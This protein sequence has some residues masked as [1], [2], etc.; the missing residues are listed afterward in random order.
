MSE[1]PKRMGIEGD[2]YG[3]KVD[4]VLDSV[5]HNLAREDFLRLAWACVD[6]ASSMRTVRLS[7]RALGA[8]ED[9]Y[10]AEEPE[11]LREGTAP[12]PVVKLSKEEVQVLLSIREGTYDITGDFLNRER[13]VPHRLREK[14][15]ITF[16]HKRA[17]L[18][19]VL[20][21]LGKSVAQMA[22]A[23]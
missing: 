18:Q 12:E 6:Q 11:T 8:I 1:G 9:L 21:D 14:G 10:D 5:G 22:G 15:L 19:F 16:G 20:T 2:G 4:A 3:E 23:T 17:L 7:Q 13:W